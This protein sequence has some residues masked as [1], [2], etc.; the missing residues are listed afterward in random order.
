MYRM[1][2]APAGTKKWAEHVGH[3]TTMRVWGDQ[4][5]PDLSDVWRAANET[6]VLY[7]TAG[8]QKKCSTAG[9]P[10]RRRAG[11]ASAHLRGSRPVSRYAVPLSCLL[12]QPAR[13]GSTPH[14]ARWQC[15]SHWRSV[16][17][18]LST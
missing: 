11:L 6:I 17:A 9:G 4:R 13:S 2:K 12:P 14:R 15:G 18:L 1:N 3:R 5:M 8:R 16:R 7:S 10:C